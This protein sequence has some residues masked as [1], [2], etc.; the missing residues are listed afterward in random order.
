LYTNI[1]KWWTD[2]AYSKVCHTVEQLIEAVQAE[3][4]RI[5]QLIKNGNIELTDFD[6]LK[7]NGCEIIP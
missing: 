6:Y 5:Q 4:P 7:Y 2:E 1:T 3:V